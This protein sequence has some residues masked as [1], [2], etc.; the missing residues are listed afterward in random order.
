MLAVRLAD[1]DP[2]AV[3]AHQSKLAVGI[4]LHNICQGKKK[5]AFWLASL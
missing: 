2:A 5:V 3:S 4:D 1:A